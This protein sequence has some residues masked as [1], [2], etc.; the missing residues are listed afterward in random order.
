MNLAPKRFGRFVAGILAISVVLGLTACG[1]P[2][3]TADSKA[4][5]QAVSTVSG[6]A[7]SDSN[8]KDPITITCLIPE[9][10]TSEWNDF[11]NSP[12]QQE[13]K[14]VTG[15]TLEIIDCDDNKYNVIVA[16]GDIPDIIRAKPSLF[17]QLI[18]GGNVISLEELLVSNGQNILK[19]V[20]KTIDFSRKFWSN[21]TDKLYFIPAQVGVDAMGLTPGLGAQIRWDYYKELGYP[22]M[23]NEDDLLNVISQMVKNHPVTDDGKKVYGVGSFNDSGIWPLFYSMASLHGFQNLGSTCAYKVDTNEASSLTDNIEGPYWKSVAFYYKA[24]KLGLLDPDAMTMKTADFNTKAT[25]GQL[26]YSPG[27]TGDFN[28]KYAKEGKG[29]MAVPLN[30][31]YQ[32]NGANYYAGWTDKSYGISK[33]SKNAGRAMD[34]LNYLWS[35]EGARTMYSGVKGTDWELV[36]GKPALKEETIKLKAI[37]GDE[38]KRTGIQFNWNLIGMSPLTVNPSDNAPL[39]LFSTE[40]VYVTSLD[41]LQKDFSDHYG[42]KYPAQ[43]FLKKLDEGVNKNQEKMNTL[44]GAILPTAP[45]DIKRME[46][47]VLDL[48]IKNAAKCILAKSDSEYQQN[49]AKAIEEFKAAGGDKVAEWYKQAWKDAVAQS[50]F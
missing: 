45:D 37:G 2:E 36:D 35:F 22:E 11:A 47:K 44:A 39:N 8:K 43:A 17:K 25:N 9:V 19:S 50:G 49:Q 21:G 3:Q 23:K 18:E 15:V 40:D 24:N 33:T 6:G 12:I 14:R 38:W 28:L 34:L 13:I 41:T 10:G 4:S 26:V 29:F 46:A 16:S 27:P 42:V 7:A 5:D 20:P 48:L 31:G 1:A 30:D 32:W